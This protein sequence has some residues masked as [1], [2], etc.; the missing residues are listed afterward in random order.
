MKTTWK[1]LASTW[2]RRTSLLTP[3]GKN[4]WPLRAS[5]L[6]SSTLCAGR[7]ICFYCWVAWGRNKRLSAFNLLLVVFICCKITF[8]R[9]EVY[10]EVEPKRQA[11]A[12]AN[13]ELSAAQNKLSDIRDRLSRLDNDLSKLTRDFEE[14]TA[15]KVK[16]SN[17]VANTEK[18]ITLANR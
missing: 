1:R 12:A 14:A 8:F 10:C 17:E 16:C 5:A 3:C 13:E 7:E 4:R 9:Y 6:G 15:E 18:T 2:R 11:L